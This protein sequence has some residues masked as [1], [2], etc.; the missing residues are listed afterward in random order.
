MADTNGFSFAFVFGKT[1]GWVLLKMGL[2]A[3]KL[4]TIR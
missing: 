3:R 4:L 1:I 2:L